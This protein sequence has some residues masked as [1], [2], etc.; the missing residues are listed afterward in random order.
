M[1]R[2]F[3][4]AEHSTLGVSDDPEEWSDDDIL[5]VLSRRG[6]DVVGNLLLGK[7]AYELWLKN[8][9]QELHPLPAA[10]LPEAYAQ[11]AGQAVALSGAGSSAAGEFPKF[12]ATRELD[13][14]LTPHVLVK[15][16]GA[17]GSTAEQRWGDLLVCEHLA[18]ECARQLEG[19]SAARSRILS[20]GGRV[21]IEVERFDR[22]GFHGRLSLC[23]L[24]AIQPTFLGSRSTEWPA[25][26][27]RLHRMEII[28][29]A[30]VA[31]VERLWWFGRL[32]ANTDMH[33]GNLSFHAERTFRLA[34]TYDM[35]PMAYAPLAGGEVP[36]RDFVPALP[37]PQQREA[38]LVAC[39]VAIRFWTMTATDTR[40]S[41]AFRVICRAST[42]RLRKVA[43]RV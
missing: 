14:M 32:I 5:W 6:F 34:P 2:Q 9:V 1:G 42:E 35:L 24:D 21:F 10:T 38:W 4:R 12:A 33:L 25:L 37:L 18:L 40:I 8:K 27:G 39:A 22:V 20:H 36:P 15:F 19:I 17:A 13:G 30:S 29:S 28:D 11:L 7:A 3:A 41:E 43:D 26:V 23:G 16:S 31:A